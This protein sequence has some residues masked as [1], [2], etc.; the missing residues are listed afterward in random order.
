MLTCEDGEVANLC[1][2]SISPDYSQLLICPHIL[3]FATCC[4]SL[5]LY[6][7]LKINK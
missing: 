6:D 5:S 3:G 2:I 1:H 7:V 4:N